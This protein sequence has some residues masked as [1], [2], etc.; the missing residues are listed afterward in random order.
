MKNIITLICSSL[1]IVS[2]STAQ[3]PSKAEKKLY[4]SAQKQLANE[5]YKEAQ[6]SYLELS[7]MNTTNEVYQFEGGLSYYFAD[8]ERVKESHYL[9]L[10]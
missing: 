10:H 2:I 9:N 3:K 6:A 7:K 4:K 8:F 5:N 1:L